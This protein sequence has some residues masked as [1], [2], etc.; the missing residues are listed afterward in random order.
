MT[1]G[2]HSRGSDPEGAIGPILFIAL[3]VLCIGLIVF[4]GWGE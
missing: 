1:R 4:L 2:L 3:M